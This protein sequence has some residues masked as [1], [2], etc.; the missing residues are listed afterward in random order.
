M[1]QYKKYFYILIVIFIVG[2]CVWGLSELRKDNF[3]VTV[4]PAGSAEEIATKFVRE[5]STKD[6][7][8][9]LEKSFDDGKFIKFYVT[10]T[11]KFAKFNDPVR[12]FLMKN[13]ISYEVIGFGSTF[14]GLDVKYPELKGKI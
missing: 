6:I 2:L 7:T 5:N 10:P 11:G 8:F 14:P 9:N 13:S 4:Y 12:I 1:N 3:V